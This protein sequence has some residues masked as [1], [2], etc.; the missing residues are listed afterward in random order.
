MK[1]F[2]ET[3]G[4]VKINGMIWIIPCVS[5]WYDSQRFLESGVYTKSFGIQV[6]F[7]RWAWG[8]YLQQGY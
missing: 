8:A 1:W 6:S 4:L 2:F 3:S 5:I 7:L